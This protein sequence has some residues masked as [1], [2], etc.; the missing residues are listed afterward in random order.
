MVTCW[1]WWCARRIY[2]VLK[3][4]LIYDDIAKKNRF[5]LKAPIPKR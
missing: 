3:L 1:L 5:E 4:V 2:D